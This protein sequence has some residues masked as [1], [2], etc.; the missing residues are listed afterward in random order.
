MCFSSV[1]EWVADLPLGRSAFTF[2]VARIFQLEDPHYFLQWL[3][4]SSWKIRKRLPVKTR[5]LT[6]L[7][8]GRSA[9]IFSMTRIFHLEDLH[10]DWLRQFGLLKPYMLMNKWVASELRFMSMLILTLTLSVR[11]MA[12]HVV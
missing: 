3:G 7:P 1:C 10:H 12:S 5:Y 6:D 9:F 11:A 2:S 8:L 4:S